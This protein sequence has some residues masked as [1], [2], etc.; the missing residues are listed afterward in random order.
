MS[1]FFTALLYSNKDFKSK[2][3]LN[4]LELKEASC[5]IPHPYPE[6][7]FVK[8]PLSKVLSAIFYIVKGS[9]SEYQNFAAQ[10]E[11]FLT[12]RFYELIGVSAG[13]KQKEFCFY[14]FFY[15]DMNGFYSAFKY[16]E[17]LFDFRQIQ[18]NYG[19]RTFRKGEEATEIEDAYLL[20]DENDFRKND[21]FDEEAF[22]KEK[23]KL[24]KPF[25]SENFI[26]NELNISASDMM[27]AYRHCLDTGTVI[28]HYKK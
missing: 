9:G 23:K 28:F 24:E 25:S 5:A 27:K 12:D 14:G 2:F 7:Y 10:S 15:D 11:L 21:L 13:K 16:T 3:L 8:L 4:A 6:E 22:W 20:P 18:N 1:T 26:N 19:L 17:N